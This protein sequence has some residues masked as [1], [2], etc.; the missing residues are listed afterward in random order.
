MC[1]DCLYFWNG[2]CTKGKLDLEGF[3]MRGCASARTEG[4]EWHGMGS[5]RR[6]ARAGI[7]ALGGW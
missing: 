3:E 2:I 6:R 4:R 1:V 7:K 5:P